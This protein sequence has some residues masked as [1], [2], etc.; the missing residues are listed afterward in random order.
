ME[1]RNAL[2]RPGTLRCRY[3]HQSQ[4]TI[5]AP[6]RQN[7]RSW[8]ELDE[9]VAELM[10]RAIRKGGGYQPIQE[11]P[12]KNPEGE[13]DHE[14]V[15]TEEDSKTLCKNNLPIVDLSNYN[16]DRKEAKYIQI[17]HIVRNLTT[18]K[19]TTEK[20]I[21]KAE[22]ELML[23]LKTLISKKAKDPELTRVRSNMRREDRETASEGHK[24][25]F[26]KL[27]GRWG[28][29]FVDDQIVV[30]IDIR[31]R[32]LDILN[33]GHSGIKRLK[34]SQDFLVAGKKWDRNQ[35]QRL[36]SMPRIR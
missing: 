9:I 26:E 22:F 32:Q 33:F 15:D 1:Q 3:D 27:S 16:T 19:K 12:A 31:R 28:L 18:N 4:S 10:R 5:F 7:K 34:Q 11:E 6:S 17:N 30:P 25:V 8:E 2:F 35:N 24:P 29:V 14:A 23:D 13:I 20:N 21:K 36:H